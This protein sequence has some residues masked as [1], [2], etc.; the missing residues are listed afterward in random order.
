MNLILASTSPYRKQ[1]L[2]RLQI[3]FTTVAPGTDESPLPD[4]PATALVERLALAK[5][6][7]VAIE[8]PDSLIIGSDQVATLN[9][10]LFGKPGNYDAANAQLSQC[11]GKEVVFYTAIALL[12]LDS[13]LSEVIVDP[14]TVKFRQ[15]TELD[16]ST[17]LRR[18][19]PYDCAGSFK[20]E[21]LGIALFESLNGSDPTS[22]EGLPLIALTTLLENAGYPVLTGDWA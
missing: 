1:L 4:E 13:G 14:F 7:A 6:L 12:G 9:G 3:P 19:Q 17:Y 21:G 18:E 20:C 8:H 5:A 10:Q 16:I 15:L 11:S 2:S 22:L